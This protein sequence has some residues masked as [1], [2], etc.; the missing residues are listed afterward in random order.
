MDYRW[1]SSR[2]VSKAGTRDLCSSC[3]AGRRGLQKGNK[4]LGKGGDVSWSCGWELQK[5]KENKDLLRGTSRCLKGCSWG[6]LVP[7]GVRYSSSFSSASESSRSNSKEMSLLSVTVYLTVYSHSTGGTWLRNSLDQMGW[8]AGFWRIFSTVNW[9]RRAWPTVSSTI[10]W[11]G[12]PGCLR[13][14]D[15]HEQCKQASRPAS[16]SL[17]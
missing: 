10:P 12:S 7:Q 9:Y 6:D 2:P 17:P 1:L 3:V 13:K 16:I 15:E 4:L 14:S 8:W 5:I 11:A